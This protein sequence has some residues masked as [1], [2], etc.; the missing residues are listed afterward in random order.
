MPVSRATPDRSARRAKTNKHQAM[1]GGE[2]AF[3][4][5]GVK[6]EQGSC[7]SKEATAKN[8]TSTRVQAK[9]G[10][11]SKETANKN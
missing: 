8:K 11:K 10:G 4:Q 1:P 9:P 5:Q 2:A 3:K 7:P 6:I